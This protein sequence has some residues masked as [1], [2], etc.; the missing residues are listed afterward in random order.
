MD[1]IDAT[2]CCGSLIF[3]IAFKIN[4]SITPFLPTSRP[5]NKRSS[6]PGTHVGGDGFGSGLAESVT[7]KFWKMTFY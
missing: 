5:R 4:F 6:L 3:G 2:G 1:A 7:G